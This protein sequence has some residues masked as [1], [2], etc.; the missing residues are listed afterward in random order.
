MNLYPE[1]DESGHGK[2]QEIASLVATPG[3]LLLS[4]IGT[5]PIRGEFTT[6]TG[7]LFLVSGN[8]L[9]QVD[10]SFVGTPLG[11]LNSSVGAVSF[12]ENGIDLCIVDGE[13]G[14]FW[15][16]AGSTFNQIT[17]PAF[18]G[19]GKVTYQDGYFIFYE[20]NTQEFFI[21][22]L[23]A[24]TFDAL[25]IASAEA[26]PDNL[27]GILSDHRDLWLFGTETI[28]IWFNSGAADFPFERIQGAFLEQGLAA[29]FSVAKMINTVFWLGRDNKGAGMVFMAQ[30]YQ[31]QRISTHAVE[32]AI[33]SYGDI[34][35]A[36]AYTYQEN[37]HHF[38]VLNFSS[39]NTTWVYD[40]ITSSW[41]ERAYNNEG[42]LER[43]RAS[44]HAYAF[45]KHV[46]GDYQNGNLYQLTSSVYSDNGAE[47]IRRRRAPH[48]TQGLK[49]IFHSSFQ[50]D[51]ETGTGLDG[52]AQGTD[53]QVMLRFSDDG[54]HSWS[55]EKWTSF[56]KIGQRKRR[57]IWRRLGQSR[58]RVYEVTISDPVKVAI[59]GA[60][61][62]AMPGAS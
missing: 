33:Q 22:G 29:P 44:C 14:Y 17:D 58:D 48:L 20:P 12:A 9:Y 36:T 13:D 54:G 5:G 30:G 32:Q 6:S 10:S 16:F 50:L 46:V 27:I 43:H 61:I 35:D 53:P 55:N 40:F 1:I 62:N 18:P 24:V 31:P 52:I 41:H 47:I 60:E 34:T 59:I 57:A 56:G 25:D 7:A 21:S 15:S 38:Y 19:A 3:L 4:T 42:V 26:Q 11:V 49:R 2:E 23:N 37:G 39:A 45:S 8:E 28:E 51:I